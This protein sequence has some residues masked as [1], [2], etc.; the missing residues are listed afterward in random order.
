MSIEETSR[1]KSDRRLKSITKAR[2]IGVL[3]ALV[4]LLFLQGVSYRL[5][6]A[7][8]ERE[9]AATEK[10]CANITN[11]FENL[12]A[13]STR[14][15]ST[16][17][18]LAEE[19]LASNEFE[20]VADNLLQR[21]THLD[22]L[23][24]VRDD[25]IRQ[26]FPLAG[27]EATIDYPVMQDPDHLRSA[28]LAVERGDVYFEGPIDLI[29]GGQ[30]IVGRKAIMKADT[31]WGFAAA[32]IRLE[33]L[34]GS[35]NLSADG[36][37]GL[38]CVQIH[39]ESS[40]DQPSA[41]FFDNT[42]PEDR[43][44][45]QAHVSAGN[46]V[47]STWAKEPSYFAKVLPYIIMGLV[48]AILAG[49]ITSTL[50]TQPMR[51]EALVNERTQDL[52]RANARLELQAKR[53]ESTNEELEQF[54]YVASHDLQEPLR[55]ITA[56]LQQLERRAGDQL[57]ERAREYVYYAK[58]GAQRMRQTIL[59]LL[60][61]SRASRLEQVKE[62]VDL[63]QLL[64]DYIA[65]R[66]LLIE[67]SQAEIQY[68]ELPVVKSNPIAV[69]QVIENLLDNALKYRQEQVAPK[70]KVTAHEDRNYWYITVRDNGIG[71]APE[72][73]EKIFIIFQRLHQ[74]DDK[75]GSGLGLAI[76]K[77]VVDRFGGQI[78]LESEL[79]VGS[80]FTFSLPK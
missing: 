40:H 5:Y 70:V 37:N 74:R 29:Q 10:E 14:A 30:G 48:L 42:L 54:A 19:G 27:N 52:E 17:A 53:L 64:D 57:D 38:F 63:K 58:D 69:K 23:Q 50:L 47:I 18:Y 20:R 79:G 75:H 73:H 67:Q 2:A 60:E 59:D 78:T 7:E 8:R 49:V 21:R 56:F 65:H 24:I 33:T 13:H 77:K 15:V 36:C 72:H 25:T 45:A 61:L 26:T 12:L 41:A 34:T 51:L 3:T 9:Y 39:K 76:V 22:A 62:D 46:W 31:L 55:M 11:N 32:I 44:F 35:M 16:L 71:I 28:M 6:V 68:D 1:T 80:A 4:V 43:Q 66:S